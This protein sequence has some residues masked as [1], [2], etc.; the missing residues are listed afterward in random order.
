MRRAFARR[1]AANKLKGERHHPAEGVEVGHH[2]RKEWRKE[3]GENGAKRAN[4]EK[5]EKP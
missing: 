5:G 1:S 3:W 2:R 4:H